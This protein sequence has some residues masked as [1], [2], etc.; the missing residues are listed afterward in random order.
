MRYPRIALYSERNDKEPITALNLSSPAGHSVKLQP[1]KEVNR[2]AS[3]LT[4]RVNNTLFSEFE[5]IES[6]ISR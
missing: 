4:L 5:G 2:R 3:L 1:K 6:E